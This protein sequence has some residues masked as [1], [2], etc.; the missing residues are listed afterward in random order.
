L[1]PIARRADDV[2]TYGNPT[3]TADAAR[4]RFVL[5]FC[6]NNTYFM[7]TAS[8]VRNV[9]PSHFALPA[10]LFRAMPGG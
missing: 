2:T 10:A 8:Q 3:L 1:Q 5:N 7:V 6:V 4:G 9:A